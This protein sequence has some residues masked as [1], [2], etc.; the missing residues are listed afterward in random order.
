MPP[1]KQLIK[2]SLERADRVKKASLNYNEWVGRLKK[3]NQH[4]KDA[5]CAILAGKEKGFVL[6]FGT[7][8][9][10]TRTAITAA[11]QFG[12]AIIVCPATLASN[13]RNEIEKWGAKGKYKIVSYQ[14]FHTSP[15]DVKGQFVIVDEA[16]YYRNATGDMSKIF[17]REIKKAYKIL[18]LTGTPLYNQ[19]YDLAVLINPLLP[20]TAAKL[21]TTADG[22]EQE[23]GKHPE[24][25]AERVKNYVIYYKPDNDP[26]N[27]PK[28]TEKLIKVKALTH[29]EEQYKALEDKNLSKLVQ[30]SEL[31][32]ARVGEIS[33]KNEEGI[34]KAI[35]GLTTY[36]ITARQI[37]NSS[38]AN[39]T[40]DSPKVRRIIDFLTM[41]RNRKKR[42]LVFSQFLAG[43]LYPIAEQLKR[44][45]IR[46]NMYTGKQT[47]KERD[48]MVKSYNDGSIRVMLLSSAGGEGLDLKNTDAVVILEPHWNNQ[49][50]AQAIGRAARFQSHKPKSKVQVIHFLT[51]FPKAKMKGIELAMHKIATDKQVKI[52]AVSIHLAR[53]SQEVM[54]QRRSKC[55]IV[56]GQHR[57]RSRSRSRSKSKSKSAVQVVYGPKPRFGP[58][59]PPGHRRKPISIE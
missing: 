15:I 7:G 34:K 17:L 37:A 23:F 30:L 22:Y 55:G 11:E 4:Q 33:A 54:A 9:G 51:T 5:V 59:L 50:A 52:E 48:A 31:I 21:P 45:N 2:V 13:W 20:A 38:N 44:N 3:L 16:H 24:R 14:K 19:P 42:V 18:F 43:G 8:S 1:Q 40:I 29:Q 49:K 57:S 47:K 46:F 56:V 10:K 36:A 58:E 12:G 28:V 35:K 6:Y 39:K 53:L 41:A 32:K 27:Y 25:F 26:V